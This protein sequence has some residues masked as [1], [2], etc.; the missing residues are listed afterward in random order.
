MLA[1]KNVSLMFNNLEMYVR[2]QDEIKEMRRLMQEDK[3]SNLTL[4]YKKIRYF[5]YIRIALI[6]KLKKEARSEKLNNLAEHLL[7]VQQF[8]TEFFDEFWSYFKDAHEICQTKPEFI[9]KCVRLIEED[10]AYL[11]NIKKIF[12]LYNSPDEK[13]RGINDSLMVSR[14]TKVR[15]T[16]MV[17]EEEEESLPQTLLDKL[18][19]LIKEDFKER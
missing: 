18:P 8:S 3:Y 7:C 4:V 1:K 13:F 5:E 9:V 14:K 15:D 16:M 6:E 19:F 10:K 17:E 11:N 12:K 2:V